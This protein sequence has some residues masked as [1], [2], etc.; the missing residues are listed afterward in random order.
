MILV[1]CAIF[2]LATSEFKI[3]VLARLRGLLLL[4]H[5]GVIALIRTLQLWRDVEMFQVFDL[6]EVLVV[7]DDAWHISLSDP[8]QPEPPWKTP[9]AW[10][11]NPEYNYGFDL[12]IGIFD[13]AVVRSIVR[14][15]Y[16]VQ[17]SFEY[18][19]DTRDL[20]GTT[21]VLRLGVAGNGE[22]LIEDCR[23]S[24]MPW[25]LTT[26]KRKTEL[27]LEAFDSYGRDLLMRIASCH[28]EVADDLESTSSEVPLPLTWEMLTRINTEAMRE[29]EI[30]WRNFI[31]RVVIVAHRF[32]K[33]KP[34]AATDND[35]DSKNA[36]QDSRE[37]PDLSKGEQVAQTLKEQIAQ[38]QVVR[39]QPRIRRRCEILNSFYLRDL[40]KIA[41]RSTKIP[42]QAPLT[43]YIAAL[44][45]PN[46]VDVAKPSER[47]WRGVSSQSLPLGRWP[48]ETT[49]FNSLM[50]QL[51]INEYISGKHQIFAVN[52]PPGT[53]K[54]TLV[55]D[56]VAATVVQRALKLV[57]FRAPDDA[58][59]SKTICC[60]VDR[61]RFIIHKLKKELTGFEIVVASSNNNAVE[62]ITRQLPKRAGLGSVFQEESYL[63]EVARLYEAIRH[64]VGQN[65]DKRSDDSRW[66]LISAPLGNR[67]NTEFF[68]D[69]LLYGP[70]EG[71]DD[72]IKRQESGLQLTLHE[73]RR[74]IPPA[75]NLSYA[76]ARLAFL[77][78][79]K[80]TEE[81]L[82]RISTE[83]LEHE[84]K[85]NADEYFIRPS[86]T[87]F[88][89]L[90]IQSRS[91]WLSERLI[92]AQ[93][94]LFLSALA[95][96]QA[97]VREAADLGKNLVALGKL[98]S[99]PQ[100]FDEETAIHIWQTLFMIVP[101]VSTT[102]ASVERMCASV[103]AG[104]FG[105][106]IIEEAGQATPQS[107]SGLL[108]RSKRALIIG[109][110]MQIQPVVSA[111]EVL[112]RH[113]CHKHEITNPLHS[114]LASSAQALADE[115]N[116]LG[117]Y[118]EQ[119]IS[120]AW[121]GSPLRV[122]RRCVE[123]MF[124][125]ANTIAYGG[126][127]T[128]G[129]DYSS[130]EG[131]QYLADLPGSIWYDT[132]GNCTNRHW[133]PRHG[134]VAC[135]I[136]EQVL[137][138]G[139]LSEPDIFFITPFR[140]VREQLSRVLAER[141]RAL[142]GS[143]DL[144][145]AIRRRVGTVHTFQGKEATAVTFILGCDE[146]TRGAARWAGEQ[147]NL[148]NVAVT[149]AKKR[150]YVIGSLALWHNQGFFSELASSLGRVRR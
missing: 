58:F 66:G 4:F 73:W 14:E 148:I 95:L 27:S 108:W 146:S 15:L 90:A 92:I 29:L 127:M 119:S 26:L 32:G 82:E 130:S 20:A 143:L 36:D 48:H 1:I 131:D 55:K 141:T 60:E 86:E 22:P 35:R 37:Q 126:L 45:H 91:P 40:Q 149:R 49:H 120:S 64:G 28:R 94:R 123:P 144:A 65:P 44:A 145:A 135:E 47:L 115:S 5:L 9:E 93:S 101:V 100:L 63:V 83:S 46:R 61:N 42:K 121:V 72:K 12:F 138:S 129:T 57:R 62:N 103:G 85:L 80:R 70:T 122:H 117:T 84:L 7:E 41:Q 136:L 78:A 68:C 30:P 23:I 6:D 69:A 132:E 113:F 67:R 98:L 53:G 13:K 97:W 112:I 3:I 77:E 137:R 105:S 133:V 88:D 34:L 87:N 39:Q 118:L 11:L 107:I 128:Y 74:R 139:Y 33:K 79:H 59:D 96:H 17:E 140:S 56:I 25:S 19:D 106:V 124:S 50:Q 114:P 2:R 52:G 110:P 116:E 134:D 21:C 102:L 111:P 150:L 147:P 10:G 51:A 54:T 109:D 81:I 125:I 76:K 104:A 38:R 43:K 89:S 16:E 71:K 75:G 142:G 24:T 99:R 31:D 18:L 8:A